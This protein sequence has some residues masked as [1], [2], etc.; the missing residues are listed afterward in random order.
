MDDTEF[1]LLLKFSLDPLPLPGF[2]HL[3]LLLY[4]LK[5]LLLV[6]RIQGICRPLIRA[7]QNNKL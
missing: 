6:Y 4:I 5:Y 3:S 2:T 7:A 1:K